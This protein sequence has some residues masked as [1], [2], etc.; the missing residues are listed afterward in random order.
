MPYLNVAQVEAALSAA[1]APPHSGFTQLITLPHTSWGGRVIHAVRLGSGA[2]GR[3]AIFLLGGVHAREWGSADVLIN[4]VERLQDAFLAN[5]G[6]SIGGASFTAAQIQSIIGVLDV[7]VLPQA[8]PDGRDYSMNT[9]AMWRKN[10]RPAPASAPTCVGV[11]LNRNY[12]FLW[13]FPA[14][15]SASS[16]VSA[17][18]DPCDFQ[19]YHGPSAT[20]EPEAQNVVWLMDSTPS[21]RFLVDV[22]S[23]GKDI[24]YMWGDDEDQTVDP[25]MSFA[26]AAFDGQRG[27]LGDAYKEFVAACDQSA[28]IALA[29]QMRDGISAVRGT[30]YTVE[31]AVGLY[32]V[33]GAV[34]DYAFSRHLVDEAKSKAYGFTVEWGEEFQPPYTE[35]QN[36]IDEVTAGLIQFCLAAI[37]TRADVY[38]K[39]NPADLGAVPSGGVFW[40][41]SDIVVRASDDGV[42][43][44]EPAVRGQTNYVYVKVRNLGPAAATSVKVRLRAVRF[45]GTE[46]VHPHDWTAIDTDHVEPTPVVDSWASIPAGSTG[47]A[48]FSL[49]PAQVDALWG[50]E[51]ASYH[52]C[53]LAEVIGCNDYN[54]AAG[55]HVWE[56]NNLAQRNISV[57]ETQAAAEA[58][59]LAFVAGN[60]FD[61]DETIELVIDRSSLPPD[62]RLQ[63]RLNENPLDLR[64][65]G[66]VELVSP[67]GGK[68][69]NVLKIEE[70]RTKVELRRPRGGVHPMTLRVGVPEGA[71]PGKYGIRVAQARGRLGVVGGVTFELRVEK[72]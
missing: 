38:I 43:T 18:T 54:S 21:I 1:A 53:L 31:P 32:P 57:V 51:A 33:A 72:S 19:V 4:F 28:A 58:L 12:D 37:D 42:F 60:R 17:S 49:S 62:F 55:V 68:R 40:D 22:H 14:K 8:N 25:S 2:P 67:N 24:L 34:D 52:P 13:N 16:G 26:N 47:T 39:D 70:P 30:S 45:P 9:Q 44:Y 3:P 10:R 61:R 27:V 11:D 20:S 6:V 56:S 41:S 29:T 7:Y 64:G 63:L 15:F 66:R 65:T 48:K 59:T 46:F 71:K 5:S 35:M 69:R 50:W 36:I 23:Y